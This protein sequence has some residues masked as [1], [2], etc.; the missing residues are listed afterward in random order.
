MKNVMQLKAIMKNI[1]KE[2]NSI[3]FVSDS[4]KTCICHG[5]ET[6]PQIV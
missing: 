4:A 6:I 1:A 5:R 3:F 2:K